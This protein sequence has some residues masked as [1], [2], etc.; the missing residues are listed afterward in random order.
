MTVPVASSKLIHYKGKAL[1]YLEFTQFTEG[2]AASCAQQVQ[3]M[4]KAGAGPDPRPARQP[5]RP[6]R[7]GGRR[8]EP[9]HQERHDRH[10]ARAQPAD[11]RLHGAGR[12]DRAEDPDGRARRPRHRL[13]GGDRHRG[14]QGSRPRQGGRHPHLRQG[15]LPG[16]D[17]AAG[18][19]RP[20]PH[21]RR[22]LHA[23]RP[24]PPGR[25]GG[26]KEGQ[27]SSPTSTCTTTRMP[28]TH[29]LKV[30]E[31]TVAAEIH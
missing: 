27:G 7:A 19:W 6:A 9:V 23:Q 14:A 5:W 2:S 8:R 13:V 17:A 30:A 24:Q 10:H 25:A 26:V 3:K 20:R 16:A 12:R 29:A 11:D 4:L 31:Q 21:R 15:R 28:G 18:R 22:V 1:G